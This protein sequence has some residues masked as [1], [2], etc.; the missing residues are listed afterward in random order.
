MRASCCTVAIVEAAYL[1]VLI[2][3]FLALA[4]AAAYLLVRLLAGA[5]QA[6]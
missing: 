2:L 1:V 3:A 6:R 4:G 5:R